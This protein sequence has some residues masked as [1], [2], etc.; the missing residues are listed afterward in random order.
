MR[1]QEIVNLVSILKL[2]NMWDGKLK[3]RIRLQ[4]VVYL[5]SRLADSP[6]PSGQFSYHHHGPYSERLSSQVQELVEAEL[7]RE[8]TITLVSYKRYDYALTGSGKS[9]IKKFPMN[10]PD[11]TAVIVEIAR[12]SKQPE[13]EL[14]ATAAFLKKDE[15]ISSNKR[16]I[17]RA[18]EL[19]PH[20]KK[21]SHPVEKLLR[22]INKIMD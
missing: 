7:V 2:L 4:K 18:V 5:I 12:S 11:G 22:R 16:A 6:F 8:D 1:N 14:L 19:K 9:T 13:L 17:A 15:K 20:C 3:G 10:L 21:Y